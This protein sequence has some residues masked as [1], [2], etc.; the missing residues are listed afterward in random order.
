MSSEISQSVSARIH[1]EIFAGDLSKSSS[2]I[3]PCMNSFY[4]FSKG[5]HE[6]LQFFF[7]HSLPLISPGT[8]AAILSVIAQ[9]ISSW[10]MIS[11]EIPVRIP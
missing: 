3:S 10:R 8:L 7:S 6:L 4:D 11:P 5:F 1:P 2:E 9:G